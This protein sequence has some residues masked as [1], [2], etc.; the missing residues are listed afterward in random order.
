MNPKH[1]LVYKITNLINGKIYIGIHI[2]MKLDD[3]YYGSSLLV[4]RAIK[5]YG[6]ENFKKEILFDFDNP[7]E[8]IAKEV[9]LVTD[10]FVSRTDTYN[11]NLGGGSF[12]YIHKN[13]M[14][15]PNLAN[16]IHVEKLNDPDYRKLYSLKI[17]KGLLKNKG[18]GFLGKHHSDFSKSKISEANKKLLSGEG[19]S[20]YGT[21]WI[22]NEFESK[23]IKKEELNSYLEKGW[24]RG[25]KL[26]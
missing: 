15:N 21:C 3:G 25:R 5:K 17:S 19:N 22:S 24:I 8:M 18:T 20:Q 26:K 23:K 13:G 10:E 11:L 6:I 12:Y 1:Y 14:S 2:T 16:K 7:E 4:K 9:E